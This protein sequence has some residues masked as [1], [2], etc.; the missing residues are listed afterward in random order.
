VPSAQPAETAEELYEHAP[1]G[2]LSTAPDGRIVRVNSTL[3]SWLGHSRDQVVE[4]MTFVDLLTVGGRIYHETHFAP[5]LRM[6]G[7]V[8]GV[9]LELRKADG[10]RLP[11][12]VTSVLTRD[13]DGRP[14][15]VRTA[16]FD[17]GDR[18]A[19]EQELLRARREADHERDR[20][21]RL[22]ATLQRSLLPPVLPEVR[23]LEL[24]AHY[25]VASPDQVGGDFYD[26]FPLGGDRW[27]LFIGDVCGKGAEAATITSL[28]RYTLRAAAVH[29]PDPIRQLRILDAVLQQEHVD[30]KRFCTVIAGVL[31]RAGRD[32]TVELAS[33]GHPP[34]LL[35]RAG[36]TAE[37]LDTPEG[38]VVGALREPRFASATAT[39]G[40]GDTLVLVTD[41]L[42]EMRVDRD[43]TRYDEEHFHAFMAALAPATAAAAVAATRTE[44]IGAG[45]GLDDD[46][47]VLALGVPPTT[48][49][50]GA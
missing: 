33:G 28:T 34:A 27:G 18:R 49:P 6:Q 38:Q 42:L 11:V 37:H 19:Y 24:A 50:G 45:D 4:R 44:L 14:L 46:T 25:Q 13:P 26:V 29:D 10:G 12:F 2:Y 17:A 3:L 40:P 47:A 41:G 16:V 22:A 35:L 48:P 30:V 39:L 8:G 23:G 1:C 43:R 5:L 31:Q 36:G 32:W 20:A 9:A 7:R 15:G 21:Q